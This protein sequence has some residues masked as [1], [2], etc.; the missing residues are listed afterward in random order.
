VAAPGGTPRRIA[1]DR[2]FETLPER[3]RVVLETNSVAMM[4]ATLSE[5]DCLSLSSPA[6][7]R[8]DFVGA[9]LAQLRVPFVSTPRP[10]GV[11]LRVDWLPTEVQRNFLDLL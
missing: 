6:Q 2:L 10:I 1:L 4:I 7:T 8:I 9:R 5:S 3:P 11:T